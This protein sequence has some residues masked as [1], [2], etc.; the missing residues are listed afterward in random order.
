MAEIAATRHYFILNTNLSN[1]PKDDEY[2]LS[3]RR[4]AAYFSPWKHKIDKIV[5]GDIVFLYR[6]GEG[7]VAFG[8][9]TGI[10]DVRDY[11]DEPEF[12]GE[13]HSTELTG[14]HVMPWPYRAE[15]IK[16]TIGQNLVLHQ[17]MNELNAVA[18]E[19]LY[20][21]LKAVGRLAT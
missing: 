3:S 19:R 1:Q 9:A 6:S 15:L 18:G 20:A 8:E 21:R 17:V 4:A 7:I 13:E 14:F 5:N 12:G 10:V 11:H 2:M 16:S